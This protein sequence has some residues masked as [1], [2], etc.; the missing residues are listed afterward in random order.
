MTATDNAAE[1]AAAATTEATTMRVPTMAT[2]HLL[3]GASCTT[4]RCPQGRRL[5]HRFGLRRVTGHGGLGATRGLFTG[6]EKQC[7]R[8]SDL[9]ASSGS[10]DTARR[11]GT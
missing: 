10:T 8:Y 3:R 11:A 4:A 6:G 7:R 2:N 5:C 9:R 1:T